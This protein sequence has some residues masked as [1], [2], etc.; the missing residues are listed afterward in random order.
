MASSFPPAS[1]GT[2]VSTV[3]VTSGSVPPSAA[4][5]FDVAGIFYWAA[6]YSGDANN[7][8]ATSECATEALVVTRAAAQVTTQS[9]GR[10][11]GD[12]GWRVG[13]RLGDARRRDRHGGRIG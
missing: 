10:Q 5:T 1:G 12:R 7:L 13:E 8:L 6:F 9:V 11:R 2:L 4:A 3:T